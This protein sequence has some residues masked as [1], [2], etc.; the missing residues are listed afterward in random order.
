MTYS[1]GHMHFKQGF[2][3]FVRFTTTAYMAFAWMSWRLFIS[4]GNS[5]LCTCFVI[6]TSASSKSVTLTPLLAEV[7][8]VGRAS[9]PSDTQSRDSSLFVRTL[10]LSLLFY[11]RQSATAIFALCQ[12]ENRWSLLRISLLS[13]TALVLT[14]TTLTSGESESTQSSY[15]SSFR[16]L[17]TGS[18]RKSGPYDRAHLRCRIIPCMC[19]LRNLSVQQTTT[20]KAMEPEVAN[21]LRRNFC[22][23]AI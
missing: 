19:Q 3:F 16:Q 13:F 21:T 20:K 5:F 23:D 6:Y 7:T 9:P 8:F 17:S 2:L 11:L 10:S 18:F 1:S 22:V 14:F 4:D 12:L 15:V